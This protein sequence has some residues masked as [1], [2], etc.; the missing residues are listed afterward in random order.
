MSFDNLPESKD[1]ASTAM[2]P[3][4]GTRSLFDPSFVAIVEELKVSADAVSVL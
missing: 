3:I 4:K 1:A 2:N